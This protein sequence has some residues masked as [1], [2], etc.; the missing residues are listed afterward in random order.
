MSFLDKAKEMLGKHDDKVDEAMDKA[1]GA[2]K[3]RFQG[4]DEQ[5]DKLTQMGKDYDFSG[6]QGGARPAEG[7][8]PP[9]AEGAPQPPAGEQPPPAP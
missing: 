9:P 5:I 1:G 6:G 7:Q 8:A 2:A 3:Q 4:H